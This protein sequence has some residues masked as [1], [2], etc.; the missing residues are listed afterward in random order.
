[1]YMYKLYGDNS[2]FQVY[3]YYSICMCIQERHDAKTVQQLKQ[4]VQKLPH[5]QQDKIS[6][7]RRKYKILSKIVFGYL[8]LDTTIAEL[9]KQRTDMP[10]FL[11]VIYAEQGNE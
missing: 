6:L 3:V 10:E 5:M 7:S 11:D 8:I 9:I 1:M 2:V 4:F